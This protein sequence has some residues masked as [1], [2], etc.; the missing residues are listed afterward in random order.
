MLAADAACIFSRARV[1]TIRPGDRALLIE[2]WRGPSRTT[3]TTTEPPSFGDRDRH[4]I[5]RS[6]RSCGDTHA[7]PPC[8]DDREQD[9][10]GSAG[11][12]RDS[13]F[14]PGGFRWCV[15]TFR[16]SVASL[17]LCWFPC[18]RKRSEARRCSRTS[19]KSFVRLACTRGVARADDDR[20]CGYRGA[21]VPRRRKARMLRGESKDFAL[22]SGDTI[23]RALARA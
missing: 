19:V 1:P 11:G 14:Q 5:G 6:T 17:T 8:T 2:P 9:L 15:D 3:T 12:S 23:L 20:P 4:R 7:G 21:N 10:R 13:E 22:I 18:A 16:D